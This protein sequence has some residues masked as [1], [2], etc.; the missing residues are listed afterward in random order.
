MTFMTDLSLEAELSGTIRLYDIDHKAS[1]IN[2]KI[3]NDLKNDPKCVSGFTYRSVNCRALLM[4]WT[5]MSTH[6]KDMASISQS[7]TPPDLEA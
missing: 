4:T 3:G 5:L 2:E 1:K 6:R 7:A